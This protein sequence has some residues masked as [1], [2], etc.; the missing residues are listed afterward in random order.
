MFFGLE[1]PKI[2]S[3]MGKKSSDEQR[4]QNAGAPQDETPGGPRE[5]ER[6]N[7]APGKSTRNEKPKPGKKEKKNH[8][9]SDEADI[10]DE[11]TI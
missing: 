5:H 9:L 6:R 7:S 3:A 10:H 2:T 8:L 1:S 4:A 11:T